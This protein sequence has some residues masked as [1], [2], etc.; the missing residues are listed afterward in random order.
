MAIDPVARSV[1]RHRPRLRPARVAVRLIRRAALTL[2]ATGCRGASTFDIVVTATALRTDGSNQFWRQSGATRRSRSDSTRDLRL[3]LGYALHGGPL[4]DDRVDRTSTRRDIGLDFPR[5]VADAPNQLLPSASGIEASRPTTSRRGIDATRQRRRSRTRSGAR[6]RPP[7]AYQRGTYFVDTLAEP[8]FGD[9]VR[10][11]ARRPD[12]A[13]SPVPGRGVGAR[14]ARPVSHVQR[15]FDSYRGTVTLSTALNRFMNVGVDYAYYQYDFDDRR[16]RSSPACRTTSTDRASA[17]TSASGRRC[18]TERGEPML[19]GKKYT[20][21]DYLTIAWRR[22]W[23]IAIPGRG[24]RV[25]DGRRLD[26]PAQPLP[27][28][29]VDPDRA[30]ARAGE[31]RP[32][33]GRRPTSTSG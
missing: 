18:S 17:R 9:S 21:D 1:R 12:D 33:D 13:T 24:H 20:P 4:S 27:R 8:V 30:A 19:P 22:R 5:A 11:A 16:P 32:P 28:V 7:A 3:R 25:G 6:G 29:H 10:L 2:D 23:F 31:L 26:V 15:H 14:S